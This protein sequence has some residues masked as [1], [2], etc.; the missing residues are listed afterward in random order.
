ML[1]LKKVGT[2]FVCE[3][4]HIKN[5][6]Q[7]I[8]VLLKLIQLCQSEIEHLISNSEACTLHFYHQILQ[9]SLIFIISGK[10]GFF[11]YVEVSILETS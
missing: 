7:I 2:F 6:I 4:G 5:S 10:M 3:G 1:K 8:R 11:V 9:R